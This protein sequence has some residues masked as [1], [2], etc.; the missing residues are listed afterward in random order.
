MSPMSPDRTHVGSNIHMQ[1]TGY[2][3]LN[4]KR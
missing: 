3:G 2:S 4:V 1:L